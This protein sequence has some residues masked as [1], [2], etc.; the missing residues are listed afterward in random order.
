M[1]AI[2][3]CCANAVSC[4]STRSKHYPDRTDRVNQG[5]SCDPT[6]LTG[7]SIHMEWSVHSD[8]WTSSPSDAKI[9]ITHDTIRGKPRGLD[10]LDP[11]LA[12]IRC[13]ARAASYRSTRQ[14]LPIPR[15]YTSCESISVCLAQMVSQVARYIWHGLFIP[16]CEPYL[17]PTLTQ[18]SS[19]TTPSALN[20]F[21]GPCLIQTGL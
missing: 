14:A 21:H 12:V 3:R 1:L 16:T 13:C 9:S 11:M 15:T 2:M 17:L 18:H 4:R 6:G 20:L 7:S 5:S 10:R 8:V 19:H